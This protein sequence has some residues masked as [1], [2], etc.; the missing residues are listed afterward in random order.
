MIAENT[1]NIDTAITNLVNISDSLANSQ[2]NTSVRSLKSTLDETT[3]LLKK[4]NKGD[5]TAGLFL[6]DD[7]LYINFTNSMKNLNEL[8]L[9]LKENPKNY[10]HFSLFGNKQK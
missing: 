3:V 7:S 1:G 2:L 6:N 10:V 4:L 8:L 9:D 5:G